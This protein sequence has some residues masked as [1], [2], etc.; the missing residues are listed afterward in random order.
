MS[1]GGTITDKVIIQVEIDKESSKQELQSV[2]NDIQSLKT[3]REQ[4]IK[5]NKDLAES[6]QAL[7]ADYLENTK[8]LELNKAAINEKTT[9][10]NA[11]IK[12]IKSEEQSITS[13]TAK[14]KLLLEER[15]KLSTATTEGKNRI[16]AIN[17]EMDKNTKTIQENVSGQEKQRLNIGNYASALDKLV[18]GLGKFTQG[19][20]GGTNQM[21]QLTIQSLKFL[22]TPIGAIIAAVVLAMAALTQYFTATEEGGDKLAKALKILQAVFEVIQDRIIR[23]G[24]ALFALITGNFSEGIDGLAHSMDGL[25]DSMDAAIDNASE[26]A[27]LLD[28]LE[29]AEIAYSIAVS[30][31]TNEIKRLIIESKNAKATE[32]ERQDALAKAEELEKTRVE[33]RLALTQVAITAKTKE[34]KVELD[35]LGISRW[36]VETEIEFAKRVAL[37]TDVSASKRKEIADLLIKYNQE[38]G[39]SLNLIEKIQNKQATA[40]EQRLANLD[41]IKK[42]EEEANKEKLEREFQIEK[43]A[44]ERELE[45]YKDHL[46]KKK[47]AAEIHDTYIAHLDEKRKKKEDKDRQDETKKEEAAKRKQAD[48]ERQIEQFKYD[49]I[50]VLAGSSFAKKKGFAGLLNTIFKANAIKETIVNTY[51]AA[52]GAYK[53]ASSIP[54]VGWILG[55]IAAAAV[56][57]VGAAQVANIAGITFARGGRVNKSGTFD[58]PSHSGGGIDYIRSDGKHRINVEGDENFYVLNKR[59]SREINALSRANVRHGGVSFDTKTTRAEFGGQIETRQAI[60]TA[61]DATSTSDIVQAVLE[62]VTLVVGVNDIIDKVG[63]KNAV[64]NTA[65]VV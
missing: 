44:E 38:Q 45:L 1:T 17:K 57:V 19:L 2:V 11:L 13:L 8:N 59:A 16:I 55:P 64:K 29:D 32:K 35:R 42:A 10:Q 30:T 43:E 48:T 54:Y 46:E 61:Q 22:A 26:L 63:K 56:A 23:V 25:A 33:Q 24:K 28:A 4:L 62:N 21:K 20:E 3:A 31:T 15:N 41:R 39:E 27:D 50:N 65:K 14:N 53:S 6:G 51:A 12:I 49:A 7:S 47:L 5:T 34:Y 60:A 37:S 9:V 58:G 52:M 36:V 40:D 18:P